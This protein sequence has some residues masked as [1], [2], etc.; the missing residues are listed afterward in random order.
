MG[1]IKNHKA[2]VVIA[3]FLVVSY[4]ISRLLFLTHLPIFTDEAIYLRWAQIALNDPDWLFIS[5]TDGKQPLFIWFAMLV[6]K[7]IEDPLFAGR[8]VSV[9]AGFFTMTGLFFLGRELFKSSKTGVI[10]SLVYIVYPFALVYDRLAL[11][12][13]LVG[14][15]SVWGLYFAIRLFK[16]QKLGNAMILGVLT[17]ISVLNKSNGFFTII[18]FPL[19]LLLVDWK[20]KALSKFKKILALGAIAGTISYAIYSLLRISPFFYIIDQKNAVF[21]YPF[22][23]W[24]S[25]PFQS[26]IGNTQALSGWFLEYTTLPLVLLVVAAFFIDKKFSKEK[27]LLFS[28]FIVPFIIL[29]FFGRVIYPRYVLFMALSLLPIGAYAIFKFYESINKLLFAALLLF[30]FG[31]FIKTDYYIL[32][33]F[34]KSGLPKTDVF[35]Y[36]TGWPAGIGINESVEFFKK[37]SNKE[38]I[39]VGTEGTFGLLPMSYEIYLGNNPNFETKGYWPISEEPPEDLQ[40]IK[41]EKTVFFVFYQP[42]PSCRVVGDAPDGWGLTEIKSYKKGEANLTIYKF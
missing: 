37:E 11:Y 26:F 15:F 2:A 36:S 41:K 28:W 5:L 33:D 23:E 3:A 4:F 40:R 22:S 20:I 42:C 1:F 14:T 38:K 35:Q 8:I 9:F 39:F 29:A 10:S 24:I 13:S 18:L 16:F 31:L 34:A 25:H 12:D 7:L 6:M 32:T 27:L 21:I 30:M 17:G 19:T